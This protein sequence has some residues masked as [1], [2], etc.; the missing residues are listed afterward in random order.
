M[1]LALTG[2]SYTYAAG[3]SFATRALVSVDVAFGPGEVVLVLGATGSG[4]S[5]LLRVA[6]GLLAPDAGSVTLDGRL[7]DGPLA[8]VRPG[9]GFVFQSPEMQLFAETVEVD[10]AFGPRNQGLSE[11][12]ARIEALRALAAVGLDAEEFGTRSPFSLSGGEARRAAIAGVL[13]MTPGYLLLDEPTAGLDLSGREAVQ[14]IVVAA[15]TRAGVVV[16]T[17]DA[18]EFLGVAD[19]VILLSEGR[20]IFDGPADELVQSPERFAEAGLRAPEILRAQML[21]RDAGLALPRFAL[22]PLAAAALI[23][24][25]REGAR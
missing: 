25:A 24:G 17:H 1:S 4:K 5:T 8:V 12:E 2:V 13:A 16:V 7:V 10:V 18:E 14:A 3:T 19:R 21:A 20:V 9:V 6:A 23:A 15:R 11:D 22:D